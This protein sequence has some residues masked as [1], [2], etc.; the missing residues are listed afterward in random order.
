[1]KLGKLNRVALRE[2]WKHEALDFTRWLSEPDNIELLSDE[3]GIG[4]QVTQTEASVGRFNVDILAEEENTGRTI[5][6][7][8]QL[9][10]TDSSSKF[11]L[12]RLNDARY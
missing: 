10:A 7:E 5:I 9:E 2:Y 12:R 6:I 1:M 3:I 8:N 4:I 11:G